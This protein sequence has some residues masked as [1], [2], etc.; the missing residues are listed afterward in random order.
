VNKRIITKVNKIGRMLQQGTKENKKRSKY[1]VIGTKLDD[2][3][4][5]N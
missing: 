5:N 4:L 3:I 2:E 1:K